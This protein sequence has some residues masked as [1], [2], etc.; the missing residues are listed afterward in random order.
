MYA[1]VHVLQTAVREKNQEIFRSRPKV[2]AVLVPIEVR[3]AQKGFSRF[4]VLEDHIDG[5]RLREIPD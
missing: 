1:R 3:K 5:Q 4:Q 2:R